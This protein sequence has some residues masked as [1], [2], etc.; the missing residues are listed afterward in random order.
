VRVEDNS[1]DAK[2]H[3][4][5]FRDNPTAQR[6]WHNAGPAA[7]WGAGCTMMVLAAA[8]LA[9]CAGVHAVMTHRPKR[10][11]SDGPTGTV[12]TLRTAQRANRPSGA[13][14]YDAA[15]RIP[16]QT[17]TNRKEDAQ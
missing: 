8:S 13:W 2:E 17:M 15:N 4:I 3:S 7:V 12:E 1:D 16:I 6:A 14:V 9:M 5:P 10:K 11:T